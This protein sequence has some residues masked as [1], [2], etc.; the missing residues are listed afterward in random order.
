VKAAGQ[1]GGRG[2]ASHEAE[3]AADSLEDKQS[4]PAAHSQGKPQPKPSKTRK[5]KPSKP[6]PNQQKQLFN[7]P[8]RYTHPIEKKKNVKKKKKNTRTKMGNNADSPQLSFMGD[9]SLI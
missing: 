2:S 4:W 9:F 5:N 6:S 3:R 7:S 1:I 8:V